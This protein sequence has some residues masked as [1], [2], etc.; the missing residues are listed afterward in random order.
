MTCKNCIHCVAWDQDGNVYCDV[1]EGWGTDMPDA[2]S[3]RG[4]EPACRK[5]EEK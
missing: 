3:C 4:Y 2:T 5:E 1:I